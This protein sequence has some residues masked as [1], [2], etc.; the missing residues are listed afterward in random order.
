MRRFIP[1]AAAKVAYPVAFLNTNS[2][3][4]LYVCATPQAVALDQAGYEAL[5]WVEVKSVGNHGETGSNTNILTYDTWGDDVTQKGKGLTNAGD[6]EI[7]VARLPTDP[8]QIILRNA[9][10]TRYYYAFK[11]ESND[12]NV[13][14][15]TPTIRYNRGLVSGPREPNGRTE[16]FDLEVFTLGLVQRQ[17][18][19]NPSS[20]GNPPVLTVAPAITGTAQVNSVLTV[21]AGT[22]T[23]DATIVRTYQW[24]AG[25]VPIAGA[26]NNTYIPVTA[27]VGKVITA[28]VTGTNNAGSAQ[29]WAAPTSAV[30]A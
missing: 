19:V 15:G 27:D 11:I 21:S 14:A 28:R 24:Y 12:R 29:G 9:A 8:G 17:I 7:E 1:F 22:F 23:G 6:P 10:L 2:G 16:D 3:S 26:T 4:K 5:V 25:G 20:A 13:D 30:I 18:K